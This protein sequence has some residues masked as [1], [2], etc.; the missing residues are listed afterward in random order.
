VNRSAHVRPDGVTLACR[1]AA[2]TS[3]PATPR[4]R[5]A[6][7]LIG[8]QPPAGA[9]QEIINRA[10]A[11]PVPRMDPGS[12][13]LAAAGPDPAASALSAVTRDAIGLFTTA[14][15]RRLRERSS[16]ECGLLFLEASRPG[17]RW[18]SSTGRG[19][20]ARTAAYRQRRSPSR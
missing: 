10:A 7:A 11:A 18:C 20:N 9:D 4:L 1:A 16:P 19:G 12:V 2:S 5:A 15:A 8:G 17:R 6:K 14:D 3:C 13:V